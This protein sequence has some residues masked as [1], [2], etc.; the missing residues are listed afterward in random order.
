MTITDNLKR[1]Q[2]PAKHLRWSVLRK[3]L[4]ILAKRPMFDRVL[5]TLLIIIQ[6]LTNGE[7]TMH[8]L[9]IFQ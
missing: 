9:S 4:A 6:S 1:V 2:K 5:N 7:Q 3:Q 8:I